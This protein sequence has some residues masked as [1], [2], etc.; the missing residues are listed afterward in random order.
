[1]VQVVVERL[2]SKTWKERS[3]IK[4]FKLVTINSLQPFIQKLH[5]KTNLELEFLNK[6]S[7]KIVDSSN[8]LNF[9]K[10]IYSRIHLNTT[11]SSR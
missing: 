2:E 8:F 5:Q 7:L 9:V 10:G 4:D 11:R 6:P 3:K 1:L